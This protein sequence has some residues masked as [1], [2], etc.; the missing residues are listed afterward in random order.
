MVGRE[1]PEQLPGDF[2][3]SR[4]FPIPTKKLLSENPGEWRDKNP[5][6]WKKKRIKFPL[7]FALTSRARKSRKRKTSPGGAKSG[8]KF[9]YKNTKETFCSPAPQHTEVRTR[10]KRDPIGRSFHRGGGRYIL[11]SASLSLSRVDKGQFSSVTLPTRGGALNP[12][13][14]SSCGENLITSHSP[15]RVPRFFF[16][17]SCI[18]PTLASDLRSQGGEST[19]FLLSHLFLFGGKE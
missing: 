6:G 2:S 4:H 10:G 12:F 17:S 18:L 5:K 14:F 9:I 15:R 7:L 3:F 8:K 16:L 19:H 1:G 11:N 13:F